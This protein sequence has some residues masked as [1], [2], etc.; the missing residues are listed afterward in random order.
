M[1]LLKIFGLCVVAALAISV[2]AVA[3]AAAEPPEFG[4]CVK[5]ATKGG[6]GYSDGKCT[7]AVSSE[8]KY[9]WLPGPGPNAKFISEARFVE[10]PLAKFCPL[11]K[12]ALEAGETER[13]EELLRKH[14]LTKEE[15]EGPIEKP[16]KEPVLLET[17]HRERVECSGV[18]AYG[19]YTGPKTVSIS[20]TTFHAGANSKRT[21]S[22]P[23]ASRRAPPKAKS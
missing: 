15:C 23:P 9:E 18:I 7:E 16:D 6:A 11:W 3:T 17:V 2:V 13:A 10:T 1:R 12:E 5:K 20:S 4:R 21:V 22:K 14:H 8:A 19:E